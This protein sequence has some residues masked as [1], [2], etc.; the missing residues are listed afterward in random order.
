MRAC[1]IKAPYLDIYGAMNVGPNHYF[2][3]GL[4]YVAAVLRDAGHS[5]SLLDPEAQG[6]GAEELRCRLRELVPDIVGISCS[7]PNFDSA[8]QLAKL[9]HEELDCPVVLGGAH[10]SAMPEFTAQHYPEF[11]V[12]V[13]GEGEHTMLELCD[14]LEAGRCLEDVKGVAYR[15]DGRVVKTDPRPWIG[16]LDSL[17]FPARDLVDFGRYRPQA[18]LDRGRR[19]ATLMTSR[20]CPYH[21]IY[22]ASFLTL[23][24]KWRAHSLAYVQREIEHLVGTFGVDYLLFQDDTFT[25]DASRVTQLCRWMIERRL[26]LKWWCL[27]RVNTVTR[28][29]LEVMQEAGCCSIS[30]GIEAGD[31]EIMKGIKKGITLEQCRQA[32]R[33]T[34]ELGIMSQCF[35]MM[36]FPADTKETV[37]KTID[38]AKELGPG[39]ASFS[40]LIPYPG[41]PVFK[42]YYEARFEPPA[43]WKGFVAV[44]A[45]PALPARNLSKKELQRL[46]FKAYLEFYLRPRQLWRIVTS[47]RSPGQFL[48]YCRGA[49][50]MFLQMALW[51]RG[52]KL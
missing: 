43:S 20:G 1:L 28:D 52:T 13:F 8:R 12:V 31:P 24:H 11:D 40:T 41:T 42:E 45:T 16:E 3:L 21:C 47:V 18:N 14:V 27:S 4:G 29:L 6:M 2:P 38:F 25:L 10:A 32:L 7:T 19:S 34:N 17:P 15:E 49:L 33:I 26:N 36:G 51:R 5:V 9:A 23:G 44:G 30:Y 48:A 22:C 39:L 46:M 50:G 37:Q 35:F